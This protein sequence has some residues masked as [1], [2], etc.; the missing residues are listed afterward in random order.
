[1]TG[2]GCAGLRREGEWGDG[3]SEG[4]RGAGEGRSAESPPH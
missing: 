3:D 4:V 1:M 2:E